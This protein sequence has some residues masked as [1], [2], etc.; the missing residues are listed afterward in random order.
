MG[1]KTSDLAAR[2][3][4]AARGGRR[5]EE[6]VLRHVEPSGPGFAACLGNGAKGESDPRNRTRDSETHAF[7]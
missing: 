7:L 2:V 1:V 5:R 4:V 6:R 3:I